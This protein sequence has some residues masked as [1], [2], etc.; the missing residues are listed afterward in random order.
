MGLS[1]RYDLARARAMGHAILAG[2]PVD[3][4]LREGQPKVRATV[5]W[6]R[7]VLYP[8]LAR[9]E[10]QPMVPSRGRGLQ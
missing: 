3:H 1:S 6:R 10:E 2:L 4:G 7:P 8:V 5:L 9:L